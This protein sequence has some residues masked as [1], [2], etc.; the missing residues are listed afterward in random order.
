MSRS[1]KFGL[2]LGLI[3]PLIAFLVPTLTFNAQLALAIVV[4]AVIYWTF[5]PVPIPYTAI[6]VLLLFSLFNVIPF[7]TTFR[8]FSGKAVWLVFSGMAL[9]LGITETTLGARLAHLVLD[10][11][12]TYPKLLLGIHILGLGL[13]LLIPSAVVRVLILMPMVLSLIKSLGEKPN[14]KVSAALVLSMVCSTYYGGVGILTASVPNLVVFGAL[15]TFGETLYW[16]QWLYYMFPVIGLI[17]VACL[18]GLISIIFRPSQMPNLSFSADK[19]DLPTHLSK[20]EKKVLTT[21][22]VGI[23]LWA[24]DVLHGIH[25]VYVGLFIVL[26][27]YLPQWGPLP[28][29]TLKKVNFPLLIYIAA[30]FALGDSLEHNGINAHLSHFFTP[31]LQTSD[32][33]YATLAIITWLAVPFDFLMDTAAVGGMLAPLILDL[34]DSLNLSPI[35]TALSLAIG[36]GVVFLPYQGAPFVVAYSFRQAKMSQ[37]ILILT[38]I[39]LITLFFLLPLNLLYWHLIGFV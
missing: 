21:I 25:P 2:I 34:S 6:I 10:R 37:F 19:S 29:D 16:S 35:A 23:I 9:S 1:Q 30:V 39:S 11:I 28:F 22:L 26:L 20:D 17:R 27:I 8:A 12:N 15:E 13:A 31:L 32:S 24:T 3:I 4:F 18:Y 5:E 14:S 7:E 36:T 38:L 33:P